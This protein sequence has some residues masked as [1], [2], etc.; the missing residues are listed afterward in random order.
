MDIAKLFFGKVILIDTD[1]IDRFIIP[2]VNLEPGRRCGGI[3]WYDRMIQPVRS[4]KEQSAGLQH[5]FT[6]GTFTLLD[7]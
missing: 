7:R 1:F 3:T 5:R 4:F 2:M 6:G